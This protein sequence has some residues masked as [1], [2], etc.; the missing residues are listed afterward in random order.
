MIQSNALS[1][2]IVDENEYISSLRKQVEILVLQW[3]VERDN[4]YADATEIKDQGFDIIIVIPGLKLLFAR[5]EFDKRKI[6]HLDYFSYATQN[7]NVAISKIKEA[8]D[9][10]ETS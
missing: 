2:V 3:L 7:V 5:R 1:H 10:S 4:T 6:I 9:E 8:I